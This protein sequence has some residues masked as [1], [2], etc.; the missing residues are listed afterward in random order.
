MGHEEKRRIL[1]SLEVYAADWLE[2]EM[3]LIPDSLIQNGCVHATV[4]VY[5]VQLR[6]LLLLTKKRILLI[7]AQSVPSVILD[8]PL[9][10]IVK[11]HPSAWY[12]AGNVTCYTQNEQYFF[13]LMSPLIYKPLANKIEELARMQQKKEE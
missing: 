4:S 2:P 13:S 3:K 12:G 5:Y 9:M 6:A 10:D 8:L 7:H 11:V 1:R